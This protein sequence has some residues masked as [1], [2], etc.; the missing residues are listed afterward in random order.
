M[1]YLWL[2]VEIF[3]K[4]GILSN[5][6]TQPGFYSKVDQS[7]INATLVHVYILQNLQQ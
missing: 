6:L 5:S 1:T 3:V 7:N 2:F 4:S